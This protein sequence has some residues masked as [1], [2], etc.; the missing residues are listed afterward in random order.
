M[1]CLY[2]NIPCISNKWTELEALIYLQQPDIVGITE[3]FPKTRERIN[4][5]TYVLEDFQQFVNPRFCEKNNRGTILFVRN[6]LE[7]SLHNRLNELSS[8]EACWYV[9][10]LSK[11][12]KLLIG[13]VYR[14]PSSDEENNIVLNN[15]IKFT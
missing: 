3:V 8:K 14:S 15:M 1:K 9:L 10:N 2:T 11:T 5:S 4:L 7:V 12:E 6:S 13:L